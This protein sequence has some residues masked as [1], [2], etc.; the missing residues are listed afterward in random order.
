MAGVMLLFIGL[1]I[2]F[3]GVLSLYFSSISA[4]ALGVL[5][6]STAQLL[7]GYKVALK[8]MGGEVVTAAEYPELH[9][10]VT[11]LSQQAGLPMPAVAVAPTDLP[12]AFAA[13]RSKN[14]A[15]VCVTTGLLESLDGD[16][17]DAVLA[18]ELAHIQNRDMVIMT[19]A[20]ALSATAFYIVRWGWVFD[21]GSGGDGGEGA[22]VMVAIIASLVVWVLSF[23]I[24]RLLSRY[25]EYT[26]DRGAVSITGDPS[27]LAAALRT[28]SA[29]TREMPEEDLREHAGMNALF[30]DDIDTTDRLT[31]WCKTHPAVENRIARLRD[32]ERELSSA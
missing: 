9:R 23:F 32:L 19:A 31:R 7:Y 6:V 21:D 12:N 11:R 1:Y 16:E 4:I 5:A 30:F 18:H 17:L 2:G 27:A 25:R 28:I 13:G 10:R 14:R 15:V 24:T 3:I 26:A 20:S 22:T 29:T 8:A